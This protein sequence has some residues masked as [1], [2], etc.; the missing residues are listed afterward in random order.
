MIM[1]SSF[2]Y[3]PT[4]KGRWTKEQW[5]A[6]TGKGAPILVAAGAGSGKT[7]VLVERVI[8]RLLNAENPSDVD[9][10]LVVTF[11][12]A[13]ASEMKE[14]ISMALRNELE[15]CCPGEYQRI[16]RQL[17]LLDR[18]FI[19]TLHS[20]CLWL[21]KRYFYILDIDP[22]VS[23]IDD[24][25]GMLLRIETMEKVLENRYNQKSGDQRFYRFVEAHGGRRGDQDILETVLRL[26]G[27]SQSL[28]QPEVWLDKSVAQYD[29]PQGAQIADLPWA[30]ELF[31]VIR[32]H[33]QQGSALLHRAIDLG[34][35]NGLTPKSRQVL[36]D[37][38]NRLNDLTSYA[39][40][41]DWRNLEAIFRSRLEYA[42]FRL[43]GVEDD[44][45]KQE[46]KRLRN[47]AKDILELI[48]KNFFAFTEDEHIQMI[49]ESKDHVVELF[50]ILKE[51]DLKYTKLKQEKGV[52]DFS[53]LERLAL[54][55]LRHSSEQES[56]GKELKEFFHEVLVDEYQDINPLQ[57]A[58]INY[59]ARGFNDD[60]PNLFMVGDVKQSIYRFRLAD[61]S[62]FQNKME[63]F[64]PYQQADLVSVG[65]GVGIDLTRNFRS[66]SHIIEG[67]NYL[68][69]QI[70]NKKTGEINYDQRALLVTGADYPPD[71]DLSVK[72]A[73][74]QGEK[75]KDAL[76][77]DSSSDER[78][79]SSESEEISLIE[80]DAFT[81]AATIKNLMDSGYKV[82]DKN[83]K[84]YRDIQYRDIVVLLRSTKDK[85]NLY[86]NALQSLN[87]PAF[88]ESGTGFFQ[89]VE[90]ELMMSLLKVIDNPRQDIPLAA[91]LRAPWNGF[92][93]EDLA[94]IRL[95]DQKSSFYTA[96]I[97]TARTG[98]QP[99]QS[100]AAGF[101][102]AL[103]RWRS[104][105]RRGPIGEL[106]EK[107]FEE[108]GYYEYVLGM[109]G[110]VQRRQNL[111]LLLTRAHKFDG[112]ARGGIS[113]FLKFYQS[114][115]ETSDLGE[116]PLLGE[117][118]N[119]VRIMSV[120]KSKGL[121]FPIIILANL[122]K[123]FNVSDL[124][125]RVLWHKDLGLGLQWVDPNLGIRRQTLAQ[126]ALIEVKKRE[127][128]A[129]ELRVLYVAMTRAEEHLILVGHADDLES[130]C[131]KWGVACSFQ[132]LPL[133]DY[134]ILQAKTYLDWIGPVLMRHRAGITLQEYGGIDKSALYPDTF[135]HPSQWELTLY[136]QEGFDK[137]YCQ[138]LNCLTD[139]ASSNQ[140]DGRIDEAAIE[141][142]L[143]K[144]VTWSYPF[145]K[146]VEHPA[147]LSVTALAR[148]SSGRSEFEEE[149]VQL[150]G[151]VS[152]QERI[153]VEE[154]LKE[155]G[156]VDENGLKELTSLQKGSATHLFLYHLDLKPKPDILD[157][158]EQAQRLVRKE[159]LRPE[160][161][162]SLDYQ[163]IQAY[164][165]S[166][167]GE[168]V[169]QA[170]LYGR[171]YR[172]WVFSM[173]VPIS[174]ISLLYDE[175]SDE[176]K[177][178]PSY[179]EDQVLVQGTI[180][181]LWI[182]EQEFYVLDYKT[183]RFLSD[184][185]LKKYKK[186]LGLYTKAAGLI[187]G[188]SLGGLYL[189]LINQQGRILKLD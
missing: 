167:L 110:G 89:A 65:P 134:A 108:T 124:Q 81:V 4:P 51:F 188:L 140:S 161:A 137:L 26:H 125:G 180:D 145:Q 128:I 74:L 104:L 41:E 88:A 155:P 139:K 73:L 120:H 178:H 166:A 159:I 47:E 117:G 91:V 36:V 72:V 98:E 3:D 102:T 40:K 173:N 122:G 96:L 179:D 39:A 149:A 184:E 59:I 22:M 94:R 80:K 133:P 70:L 53:D 165:Q 5:A 177:N 97:K 105:A 129:E 49:R 156:A 50:T 93:T 57:D 163:G 13:A 62:L 75:G 43:N 25:E 176:K 29:L 160:E 172:E 126:Q 78:G 64:I 79:P 185:S 168:R 14:R 37:E 152:D 16:H 71:S 175:G 119:L 116:A 148:E 153:K 146:S 111:T 107:L 11:T 84:N 23:V 169:R 28:P 76:S 114:L 147:K 186:Q 121:Q 181:C 158:K 100:R 142:S 187:T 86:L 8:Q 54:Q 82:F 138:A 63:K 38:L 99:L 157:L 21:V 10:L 33:L 143:S 17:A 87:I 174:D 1:M 35:S 182:E 103:D 15:S 66:R 141:E 112:F 18:A 31:Y 164:L 92:S 48:R 154:L 69:Q 52:L 58:I 113:R 127:M 171:L 20:F 131:R 45:V 56:P 42:I 189:V 109:P 136:N 2:S 24:E 9:R 183:D 115:E 68:F 44:D 77:D 151:L 144:L 95:A 19:C 170:N 34:D 12:E 60:D 101:L 150:P 46:I 55:I 83:N 162:D 27:F 85:A 61:P 30:A 32:Q 106:I 7:A 130:N 132:Q 135:N 118:D 90:I 123:R 6:I 67:T